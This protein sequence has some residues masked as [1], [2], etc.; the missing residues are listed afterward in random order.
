LRPHTQCAILTFNNDVHRVGYG[1]SLA[2]SPS[3]KNRA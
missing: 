3:P 1:R 2:V